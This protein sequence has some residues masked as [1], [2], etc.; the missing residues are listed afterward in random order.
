MADKVEAYC[1]TEKKM[2]HFKPDDV[3]LKK[4]SNGKYYLSGKCSV[5]NG[6]LSKFVKNLQEG[7][8]LLD[9]IKGIPIIG[10]ITSA[11]FG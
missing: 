10:N 2:R 11:L 1:L 8:G 4:T 3:E 5:C 9:L 7:K 6:K